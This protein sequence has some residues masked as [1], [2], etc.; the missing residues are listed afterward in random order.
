MG[1]SGGDANLVAASREMTVVSREDRALDE[2]RQE[3]LRAL[4]QLLHIGI[5]AV[6]VWRRG[7]ETVDP[8]R[9]RRRRAAGVLG[10][11]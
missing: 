5:A 3:E 1:L 7:A 2:D 4:G 10:N 6:L 11:F 9:T 8:A